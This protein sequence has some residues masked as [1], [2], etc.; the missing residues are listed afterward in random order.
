MILPTANFNFCITT[1]RSI[2]FRAVNLQTVEA[3]SCGYLSCQLGVQPK[4]A[5]F[6][7]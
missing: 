2:E 5:C 4:L 7:S 1:R 6:V 3:L